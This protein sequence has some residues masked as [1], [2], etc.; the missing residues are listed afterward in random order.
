MTR[1]EVQSANGDRSFLLCELNHRINNEL[2]SAICTVSAKAVMAV[3]EAVKWGSG[4]SLGKASANH[5]CWDRGQGGR[6]LMRLPVAPVLYGR[7]T[8]PERI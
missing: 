6:L 3:D 7:V 2:T 5:A 1:H 4:G 8:C